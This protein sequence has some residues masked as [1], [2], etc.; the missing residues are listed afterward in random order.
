M[1]PENAR[2]RRE[3]VRGFAG[4]DGLGLR[5]DTIRIVDHVQSVANPAQVFR[6]PIRMA[7]HARSLEGRQAGT[8]TVDY[9]AEPDRVR[10][11]IQVDVA[12]LSPR[13]AASLGVVPAGKVRWWN[14]GGL[15]LAMRGKAE[16]FGQRCRVELRCFRIVDQRCAAQDPRLSAYPGAAKRRRAS[17]RLQAGEANCPHVVL[18]ARRSDQPGREGSDLDDYLPTIAKPHAEHL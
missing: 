13:P 7:N 11:L 14:E 5:G 9:C 17:Q 8:H 3:Q 2:R 10:F 6:P 4:Q 15:D 16:E 12:T 1:Q 18:D